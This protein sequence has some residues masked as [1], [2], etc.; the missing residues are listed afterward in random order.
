MRGD[1]NID[2]AA[3]SD[4]GSLMLVL[5][6]EL[7]GGQYVLIRSIA[8]RSTD[9]FERIS[10]PKGILSNEEEKQLGMELSKIALTIQGTAQ[11]ADVL[12]EFLT[13]LKGRNALPSP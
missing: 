1:M 5:P 2:C 9:Q 7:G 6:E 11:C 3:A 13:V 10:G 12:E 4:G 8:S